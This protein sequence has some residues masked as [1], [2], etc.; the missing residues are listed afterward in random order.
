M[1]LAIM[2]IRAPLVIYL[3]LVAAQ[4]GRASKIVV[5]ALSLIIAY[6]W[7]EYSLS[8]EPFWTGS[9]WVDAYTYAAALIW[10]VAFAAAAV[11]A[12]SGRKLAEK[13]PSLFH[14]AITVLIL[15][16]PLTPL[17]ILVGL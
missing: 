10:S 8:W 12:I 17:F 5:G 9:D 6:M 3:I 1:A 11:R 2:Y 4:S 15:L 13:Y 7:F 16:I 14:P